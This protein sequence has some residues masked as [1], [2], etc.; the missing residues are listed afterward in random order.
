MKV[1][2]LIEASSL[3]AKGGSPHYTKDNQDQTVRGWSYDLVNASAFLPKTRLKER[4]WLLAQLLQFSCQKDAKEKLINEGQKD[5]ADLIVIPIP[6]SLSLF[7]PPLHRH[8]TLPEVTVLVSAQHC[9]SSL[10]APL[11]ERWQN[12]EGEAC[13]LVCVFWPDDRR[14][15]CQETCAMSLTRVWMSC[16]HSGHVS[17]CKAH[18]I[19]IPL[20][21]GKKK[22]KKVLL[23]LMGIV[24]VAWPSTKKK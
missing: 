11:D 18:S 14:E 5:P 15:V 22:K 21:K 10:R 6:L 2:G 1:T 19:H 8:L 3:E 17:N 16:R 23:V 20:Q 9:G 24:H 4:W 7:C 12:A 13:R